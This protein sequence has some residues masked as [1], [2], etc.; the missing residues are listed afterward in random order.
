MERALQQIFER[1]VFRKVSQRATNYPRLYI[2]W[3]LVLVFILAYPSLLTKSL[4]FYDSYSYVSKVDLHYGNSTEFSNFSLTQ[5]WLQPEDNSNALT[6]KF[7]LESLAFQNHMLSNLNSSITTSLHSPFELWNNSLNFLQKDRSPLLTINSNLH[8]LPRYLFQGVIKVNGYVSSAR[9]LAITLVTEDSKYEDV[10]EILNNNIERLQGISNITNFHI[11][12][13]N[14]HLSQREMLDFSLVPLKKVDYLFF[15][16]LYSITLLYFIYKMARTHTVK[17]KWGIPFAIFTQLVLSACSSTTLTGFL[18]KNSCDSIPWLL[19]YLPVAIVSFDGA[20]KLLKET[21][22]SAVI[23]VENKDVAKSTSSNG[24]ES[25]G[26]NDSTQKNF[27]HC[28][29]KF[30]ASFLCTLL[31]GVGTIALLVPFSRK[32]TFFVVFALSCNFFLQATYLTAVLS[33]DYRRFSNKDLLFLNNN[34]ENVEISLDNDVEKR[35]D[36]WVNRIK[37]KYLPKNSIISG[38]LSLVTFY[39]FYLNLRFQPARSSTSIVFKIFHGGFSRLIHFAKPHPRIMFDQYFIANEIFN[40]ADVDFKGDLFLRLSIKEQLFVVR[41]NVGSSTSFS[42]DNVAD[43]FSSSVVFTYKFDFYYFFEFVIFIILLLAST[44][45]LLHIL[46]QGTEGDYHLYTPSDGKSK[47]S[48]SSKDFKKV[49]DESNTS[50]H[51]KELSMGGHNLDIIKIFTSQSPFIVSV[52]MDHK[53]YVWSPMTKP[54]PR[55][56]AIPLDRK[57]W[58]IVHVSVS[59][60]GDCIAFFNKFGKIACWSRRSMSFIWSLRMDEWDGAPLEAFFRNKTTPLF[61]KK[62]AM[63]NS[64]IT[65][66]NGS[67]NIASPKS[68]SMNR[69]GSMMSVTSV[70]SI[71]SISSS[72]IGGVGTSYESPTAVFNAENDTEFLFVTKNGKINAISSEGV[73][74]VDN[75]TISERPLKSCKKLTTPRMNDRL[76]ICDEGGDIY[77]STVVN[78]KWKTR[79]LVILRNKFNKGQGL[80]TPAT[81][82]YGVFEDSENTKPSGPT[83]VYSPTDNIIMLVPFVGMLLKTKG[84]EAELIDVQTG[85]FI[86]KFQLG[87][88]KPGTLRVFHDQPTHCRFCGSASVASFSIAYTDQNTSTL[89]MHTFQLESRTKTSICLRVERDPREI[90]CLGLEAV[91]ER[92]HYLPNIENWNV[93]DNNMAI[94]IRRKPES[95][96][97]ASSTLGSS[98]MSRS[99]SEAGTS[100]S[101][102]LQKR[103]RAKD[104]TPLRSTSFKI[105]N[106]WEGWTMTVGGKVSFYEIPVGVNGLLVSR[107]GPLEKFGAKSIVVGFGNIMKMFY[108]G[109]EEFILTDE[110]PG[111]NEENSGLKFVNRRRDRLTHKKISTNYNK[112]D[113]VL[114]P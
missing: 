114:E 15:L 107:I 47:N 37:K 90:R 80:M 29:T 55:P 98:S 89:V 13:S 65:T 92:T 34:D 48:N 41:K 28:A 33:L 97:S 109:H 2:I 74:K 78:N 57:F 12:E 73:L 87:D 85:T 106:I 60:S 49:L 104:L 44:L 42:L 94:G 62:R 88:F 27:I 23:K 39:M 3:P 82:K 71:T 72:R 21:G 67:N 35:T 50:F 102:T 53:V 17:S 31:L 51:I 61:M 64:A 8:A 63:D 81:L 59:N 32:A 84:N 36:Y 26:D 7:L 105:H 46:V 96:D 4:N 40:N 111:T 30:N 1:N 66:G 103:S 77:V 52:G 95:V 100:A 83:P 70:R 58:P 9:G 112:L 20:F 54:L 99:S 56:T 18:F 5:V 110:G 24:I 19:L 11:F 68:Y 91:V 45:L 43:M 113:S 76:V 101:S 10:S 25:N 22:G 6:K 69:R 86:K 16:L 38:S 93:S 108:L 79:K 75:L 14:G